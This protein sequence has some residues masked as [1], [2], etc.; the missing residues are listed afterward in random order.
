MNKLYL[1]IARYEMFGDRHEATGVAVDKTAQEVKKFL[2]HYYPK[3]KFECKV[4]PED[5]KVDSD[6]RWYEIGSAKIPKELAERGLS[7][8]NVFNRKDCALISL[9]KLDKNI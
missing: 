8:N 6:I 1:Y 4:W 9:S 7:D 2:Q 3:E 5:I